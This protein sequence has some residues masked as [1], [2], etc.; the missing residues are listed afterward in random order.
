ML[1]LF[2]KR[3][4]NDDEAIAHAHDGGWQRAPTTGGHY[5]I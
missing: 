2:A 1:A 5:G 4:L 3:R